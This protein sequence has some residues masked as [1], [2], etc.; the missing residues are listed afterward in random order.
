MHVTKSMLGDMMFK[1]VKDDK[2]RRIDLH[3]ATQKEN[4]EDFAVLPATPFLP[5][6]N[7]K[8]PNREVTPV[9]QCGP[10]RPPVRQASP[11]C[12]ALPTG[13]TFEVNWR[14][15]AVELPPII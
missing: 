12:E 9:P 4:D 15:F 13:G 7:L 5:S 11:S 1:Y 10:P 6:V 3:G 14:Q 8:K 2:P